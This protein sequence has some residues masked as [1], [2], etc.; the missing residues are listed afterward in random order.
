MFESMA[1]GL[2]TA[3]VYF[4]KWKSADLLEGHTLPKGQQWKGPGHICPQSVSG[5][6]SPAGPVLSGEKT[7]YGGL[8]SVFSVNPRWRG[9]RPPGLPESQLQGFPYNSDPPHAFCLHPG[10]V[11]K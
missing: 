7:F 4:L 5:V 6:P 10:V 1:P 3:P 11:L 8:N 2:C 9:S